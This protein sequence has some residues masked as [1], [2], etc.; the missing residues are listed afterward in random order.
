MLVSDLK[1]VSSASQGHDKL[2][3]Q[4]VINCRKENIV[5]LFS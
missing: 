5:I 3:N 1:L 2:G 4:V